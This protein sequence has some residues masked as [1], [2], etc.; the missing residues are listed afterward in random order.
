MRTAFL[1][2]KSFALQ[3][4]DFLNLPFSVLLFIY[5]YPPGIGFSV[6]SKT[7]AEKP[8]KN[9]PEPSQEAAGITFFTALSVPLVVAIAWSYC[10]G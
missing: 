7:T 3:V 5:L 1:N 10:L 9:T 2:K 8:I 4:E 6:L